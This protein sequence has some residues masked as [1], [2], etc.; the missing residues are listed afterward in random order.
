VTVL[1][2]RPALPDWLTAARRYLVAV[3]VGNL[4]WEAAQMP[5]YTLWWTGTTREIA[6]AV[7]HCTSGD[8]VIATVALTVALA[9]VGSPAWPHRRAVAV[10]A[11][12][13]IGSAGYTV[14]SEY[15]NTVTQRSWSYTAAMPRLP[16]LGTGL[17]P[18]AQWLIIPPAALLWG[19]RALAVR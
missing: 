1:L 11:A 8:I 2:T 4:V 10:I 17:A 12:V 13:A 6:R 19:A 7:L 14:Y 3:T 5:L 15:V 9:L 16:P 18:L